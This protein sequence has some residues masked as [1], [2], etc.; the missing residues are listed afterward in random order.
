MLDQRDSK[1]YSWLVN[2]IETMSIG[3]RDDT[4]QDLYKCIDENM[5]LYFE[6]WKTYVFK[7]VAN[8]SAYGSVLSI[9][10]WNSSGVGL[11][12]LSDTALI[13]EDCQNLISGEIPR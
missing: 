10:S 7:C 2:T 13:L 3:R 1:L 4:P 11:E 5:Y 6:M 8:V 12:H 9:L